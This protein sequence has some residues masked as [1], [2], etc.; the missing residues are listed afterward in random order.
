MFGNLLKIAATAIPQ[1]TVAWARF[2]SREQDDRGRWINVYALPEAVRGS[3]QPVEA[4]TVKEMGFDTTKVYA[5][6]Y[7][8]H[9]M[10]DVQRGTSP[11][12]IEF[13]G[14]E[15]DIVGTTDWYDQDGWKSVYCVKVDPL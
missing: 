5:T 2:L 6:L 7:T 8:A 3:F 15:Y 9:D 13:N 12:K 10:Q 14:E 1:Q 4:R 11:D